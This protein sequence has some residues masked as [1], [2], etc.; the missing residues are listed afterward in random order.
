MS[1]TAEPAFPGMLPPPPGVTPNLAN[2]GSMGWRLVVASV[3]CPFFAVL[4]WVL[5]LYTSRRIVHKFWPDDCECLPL[6][7]RQA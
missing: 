3:L 4:L 7:D 2:P 1:S 6:S 5:R